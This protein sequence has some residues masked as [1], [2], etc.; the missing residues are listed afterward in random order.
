MFKLTHP[1]A[2]ISSAALM[3]AGGVAL[4]AADQDSRIETSAKNSYNFK[5]YL[6]DDSIKVASSEGVVTLTGT[7]S[8]EYH[9][10]LAEET[11]AGMTGVKRV[12]NQLTIIGDQ[13]ADRS[14]GWVTMK[15]KTVLAFHKNVSATDT[16]V[17][18]TNGIVTL[19]GKADSQAQKDLT[20]EYAKDVD[21][22]ME[23]RNNLV[24][25]R[26]NKATAKAHRTMGEKVD[27]ASITAQIKT[28]LLF[29][30]STHA[31]ATKVTTKDGVVT[32]NG[33][34]QNAAERDLA[35][36]VAEDIDGVSRVHNK[37]TVKKS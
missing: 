8:F 12:D 37:M 18:T 36:K 28:S 10:Q 9:K 34:A 25:D 16:D 15:V 22:A 33:E 35:T 11:V 30:K 29:R 27:D 20:G 5:T 13:P 3:L 7:V 19:S 17:T 31:M 26:P 24:V 32:L 2:I 1:T 21:G 14:D 6:K 23:V 4:Q